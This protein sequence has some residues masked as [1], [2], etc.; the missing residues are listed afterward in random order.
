[1]KC[2]R[3]AAKATV[4]LRSHNTAFCKECF[5]FFFHRNVERSIERERMF[6]PDERVLVAVSG[7]KD[8][9]ALW[10]TLISL[11]YQTEGLYLDLGIGDYSSQ[12][13]EK[14]ER[15]ARLSQL[16]LRIV[17]LAEEAVAVP[18]AAQF[19]RRV[20]CAA[21]GTMKRHF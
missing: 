11:G 5:V 1:M 15:F 13:R 20:P 14:V 21:C 2:K 16:P 10:D 4:Q 6:T 18:T 8:S 17:S 19:T 3:C 9:L 12:S 7:G